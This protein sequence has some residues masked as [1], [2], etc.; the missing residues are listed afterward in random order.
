[1]KNKREASYA[2]VELQPR[3]E[4]FEVRGVKN[5][6]KVYIAKACA[7]LNRLAADGWQAARNDVQ[8]F[9]QNLVDSNRRVPLLLLL[10]RFE[11]DV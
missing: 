8:A 11:D 6:P 5:Y 7:L 4:Y 2:Y 9:L 10:T 1:M 3:S